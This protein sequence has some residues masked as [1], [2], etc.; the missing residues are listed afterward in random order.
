MK[1][2]RWSFF[3]LLLSF[4]SY[5]REVV[6]SSLNAIIAKQTNF[7]AKTTEIELFKQLTDSELSTM[8]YILTVLFSVF[9]IILSL[10]GLKLSF[11][12][13]TAIQMASILYA[14]ILVVASLLLLIGVSTNSFQTF[15]PFLRTL[16]E[17]LHSPIIFIVITIVYL[18]I[19]NGKKTYI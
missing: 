14:S 19:E 2:L 17:Y 11:K 5:C 9:F 13:A 16:I 3:L 12:K 4:L 7:Y 18:S 1:K 15:Y 6:F 8:K 10:M